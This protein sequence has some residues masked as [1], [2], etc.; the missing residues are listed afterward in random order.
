M[1]S[2]DCF[3]QPLHSFVGHLDVVLDFGWHKNIANEYELI[4][5]SKDNSLRIWK[6]DS[7]LLTLHNDDNIV[8]SFDFAS[9]EINDNQ[10]SSADSTEGTDSSAPQRPTTLDLSLT[11]SKSTKEQSKTVHSSHETEIKKPQTPETPVNSLIPNLT[12]EFSLINVNIPNIQI[13]ELNASKRVCVITATTSISCRLKMTFPSGYPNH[14]S[15]QFT[16]TPLNGSTALSEEV[17]KELLKVLQ[18]T[19]FLQVKRNR[20]CLEPCLRQFIATLERLTGTTPSSLLV[21]QPTLIDMLPSHHYGSYLDASVPFPR[22]SG[23]RFCSGEVCP[24]K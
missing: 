19:A 21:T 24:F 7:Q 4:T 16:L 3:D 22:T 11:Q 6:V 5:W 18:T 12:Q 13:E 14:V 1:W 20:T 15:P 9:D 8:H 2:M 17:K 23:A 10:S